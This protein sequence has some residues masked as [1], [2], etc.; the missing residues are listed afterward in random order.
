MI[1]F[2]TQGL[3]INIIST[4]YGYSPFF[5]YNLPVDVGFFVVQYSVCV[6]VSGRPPTKQKPPKFAL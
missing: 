2:Y 5:L 6:V 4:H 3:L 1:W